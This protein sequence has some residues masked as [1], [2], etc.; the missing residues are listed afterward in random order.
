[1]CQQTAPEVL[2]AVLAARQR[3]P[4]ELR[5]THPYSANTLWTY[6]NRADHDP[7]GDTCLY[8]R[9]FDGQTFT[10]AQLRSVF[11]DHVWRGSDIYPNVHKTLWNRESTCACLLIRE[12]EGAGENK[13]DLDLWTDLGTDWTETAIEE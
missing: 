10:G 3:I 5:G 2:E 9:F 11:P 1:M 8:C 7:E 4:R 13:L 6:Y 12:S